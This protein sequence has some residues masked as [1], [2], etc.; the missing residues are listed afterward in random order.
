M[1]GSYI[2]PLANPKASSGINPDDYT[3]LDICKDPRSKGQVYARTDTYNDML[4]IMYAW[5]FP[6]AKAPDTYST[7][8][9]RHDWQQIILW[10]RHT[11]TGSL[12][13]D[14]TT[15]SISYSG[16]A[17]YTR[18]PDPIYQNGTVRPLVRYEMN[19]DDSHG[20]VRTYT[21]GLEQDLV[22][23]SRF[24][25]KAKDSSNHA[26]TW[27]TGFWDFSGTMPP[28]SDRKFGGHLEA[29]WNGR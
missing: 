6:M 10:L 11:G 25:Q 16:R 27:S 3:N 7:K 5:Y 17:G 29:A 9:R 8:S 19:D 18:L 23:W 20:L 26:R 2:T 24:T 22:E 4:A 13:S 14:Y 15:D 1:I 21:Q 12:A 28:F